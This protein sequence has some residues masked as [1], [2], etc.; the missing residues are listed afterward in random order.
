MFFSSSGFCCKSGFISS[1]TRYWFNCVNMIEIWRWPKASYSVS[2]IICGVMPKRDA[3]LRSI[4]SCRLQA[5][6][7]LIA[8]DVAQFGS[9]CSLS[10]NRGTQIASSFGVGVFQTVLKLRAADAILHRQILHRLHEER[11]ALHLGQFGLQAADDVAGADLAVFE[12][13]QVDLNASA[14]ERRVGAV[15]AD[16]GRQALH[17]RDPSRI[18]LASAC[19][20]L[21][22]GREGNRLRRFGD[23]QNHAGVLHREEA[24]G[25]DP[26]QIDGRRQ[27][28][29][30]P[31]AASSAGA[32]APRVKRPAV[33]AR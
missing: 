12:R 28:C 8:G 11:D 14:V 13:L 31:P 9:A 22:H 3:V 5:A 4:T 19:W 32:A 23:A 1:T 6:V 18:T 10:R 20:R 17:R 26:E 27:R 21:R 2:S 15:D 7:L 25:D 29:Q 24:L 33:K 16:E 30:R